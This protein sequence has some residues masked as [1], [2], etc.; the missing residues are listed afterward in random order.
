M[1]ID[2]AEPQERRKS[3][4]ARRSRL[5]LSSSD[6][7]QALSDQELKAQLQ[8]VL[9]LDAENEDQAN[10]TQKKKKKEPKKNKF[11]LSGDKRT[12]RTDKKAFIE[13]LPKLACATF[14]ARIDNTVSATSNLLTNKIRMD[15]AG[16]K[17]MFASRENAW[18]SGED[19]SAKPETW[20]KEFPITVKSVKYYDICT[21]FKD[22]RVDFWDLDQE[23]NE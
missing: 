14:S 6:S 9:K 18:A 19:I 16:Y 10:Q 23:N 17:F 15:P 1:T 13:S 3:A 4:A 8:A 5:A 11:V 22:L 21:A 20:T 12:I 7:I 2:D